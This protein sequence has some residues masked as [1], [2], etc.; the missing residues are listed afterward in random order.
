MPPRRSFDH[1]IELLPSAAPVNVRPYRYSPAQKDEIEKQLTQ[2]LSDGIITESSSPYASPVLL[3]RKKDNS[4]RFCVDYRHLNAMT[5]KN[6]HPMPIVDELIDEL[7]GAQWFSKLDFRAGYHQIRIDQEDTHNTAFKTHEGLYEFLVMPFGLTNAPATFQSV[8]NLIFRHL[9]RKGVL[10]FMDDILVYSASLEEHLRLLQEVFEI[11]RANHFFIKLSKCSFAQKEV[12]Y[13][14]HIISGQG[15]ATEPSKVQAVKQWPTPVNLKQLRGFL[16]LTGY[17]RKFIKGYGLISQPLTDLLKKAVPFVWTSATE[18]AFQSLKQALIS[19]PVLA[20]P[21]FSRAFVIETDAS[22]IGFGAVLMQGEHPVAYL[23]KPVYTNNQALSTYE[24]ECMAIIFA[25][26][27]WRPYLLHQQFIIRTDH[28]SLLHLTQQRVS[29]KLQHKALMKLMDLDFRIVYKQ[30]ATNR[31]ADAL[32]RCYSEET[33]LAVSSCNPVWMQRVIEGYTDDPQAQQLPTELAVHPENAKGYSLVEGLIRYKGRVWL[34]TNTLAQ[35]HVMQALYSSAV[36]GHSGA[37]ATY[38]RIKA[39]F[40]WPGMRNAITQFVQSCSV[41][42]QAKVEHVKTPGLLQPLPI[43]DQAWQV[44]YLD[45]IEGLPKSARY[46]TILVV[47]DKF[48]K[49]G[50]FI[51]LA[52]PFTALQVAR[53]YLDHVYKLHGLP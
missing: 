30:G 36:G 24:K 7:A 16:G 48:T 40:A 1:Q 11:I 3:V 34:G 8:M 32:S 6:K 23:S 29:S 39:I 53:S 25:I 41:C 50:Q 33:V 21:Y 45:F 27:K 47:I 28:Q 17:Y 2:M 52:H 43:P 44:V 19:A 42:Q 18:A 26:E 10:V 5:V 37:L 12:E 49:Y 51:P 46:D 14:G 20:I 15:V 13:L 22:D 35:N 4:W 31:A 38:H 9:L